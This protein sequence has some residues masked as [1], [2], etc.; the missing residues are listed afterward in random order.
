MMPH[1]YDENVHLHPHLMTTG[2]DFWPNEL[3]N[4]YIVGGS[5]NYILLLLRAAIKAIY[6]QSTADG[7]RFIKT[8]LILCLQFNTTKACD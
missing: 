2:P 1:N 7:L 6:L 4:C 8:L 5:F 3:H